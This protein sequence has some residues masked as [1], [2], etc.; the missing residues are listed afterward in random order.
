MPVWITFFWVIDP[1]INNQAFL[2]IVPAD[3]R[4][5]VLANAGK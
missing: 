4:V 3:F 5:K 1:K 2:I